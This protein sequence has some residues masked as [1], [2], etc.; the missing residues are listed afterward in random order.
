MSD[1]FVEPLRLGVNI[2]GLALQNP[3]MPASG[4]F[5]EGMES[6]IDF[7]ALA[8]VVPKSITK[9]PRK[10]N[11]TPRVCEVSAGMINSIGIQSPGIDHYLSETLPYYRKFDVPLI[12]S[13]SADSVAEFAEMAETIGRERQSRIRRLH[14]KAPEA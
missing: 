2:G 12:S 5:G 9:Y 7:N 13:I 4:A 1:P 8:A 10:G 3:V 6:V 11:A 14:L